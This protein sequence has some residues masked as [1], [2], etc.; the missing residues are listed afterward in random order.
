[1]DFINN[2]ENSKVSSYSQLRA[3][4]L[5]R[6]SYQKTHYKKSGLCIALVPVLMV[7]AGGIIGMVVK[8]IIDF[9]FGRISFLMCSNTESIDRFN[10]PIPSNSLKSLPVINLSKF[11]HSF[12]DSIY[13]SLNHYLL[14]EK[15]V[16][17]EYPKPKL[18][19]I[20]P[21]PS[22][23]WAFTHDYSTSSPYFKSPNADSDLILDK[24]NKPSPLGGWFN[25]NFLTRSPVKL[26]LNQNY[27]YML[28]N[29][30]NFD[31]VGTLE[32]EKDVLISPAELL[33]VSSSIGNAGSKSFLP[34]AI[35]R[36]TIS[37]KEKA[38]LL[39]YLDTSYY[40]KFTQTN[41][42]SSQ[43]SP[44][45]FVKVPFYENIKNNSKNI[46][47][48]D[49]D[50]ILIAHIKDTTKKLKRIDSSLMDA[51]LLDSNKESSIKTLM[52]YYGNVTPIFEQMPWGV[53]DLDIVDP[54]SRNWK[55]TLQIGANDLI[56]STGSYPS[57]IN[58]MIDQQISL[59]NGFLRS[60]KQNANANI[61]HTMRAMPQLYYYEYTVPIGSLVGSS[62]YPFGLT[63][64]VSMFVLILVREK[65]EKVLL[66]LHESEQLD[67][68]YLLCDFVWT[69]NR[70]FHFNI[71]QYD[72]AYFVPDMASFCSIPRNRVD[73][74]CINFNCTA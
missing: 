45:S 6:I 68:I 36:T 43:F 42:P 27:P 31:N 10:M 63:F 72:P 39:D 11:K 52:Y 16:G 32:K 25:S 14:P 56:D 24:T 61:V 18:R 60:S 3:L 21:N 23:G 73:E 71:N 17:N 66:V 41:H 28:I 65:Q 40:M 5:N 38:Y 49:I 34:S 59:S 67:F 64:M 62:L 33:D 44:S 37:N 15:I 19:L 4:A 22:C 35:R 69:C 30:K 7:A 51:I 70:C 47:A 1:M 53:L 54:G 74:R 57:A 2:Q 48:S 20:D 9:N 8:S 29:T 26:L 13:Y 46:L 55:Y 12:K 50:D 58:R